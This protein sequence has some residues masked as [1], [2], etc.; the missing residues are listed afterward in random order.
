V[1][2]GSGPV[3]VIV[4]ATRFIDA[5]P[6]EIPGSEPPAVVQVVLASATRVRIRITDLGGAPLKTRPQ[7]GFHIVA[8]RAA[9]G[10][11]WK[12]PERQISAWDES[13]FDREF[14]G[15][16]EIKAPLPVFVSLLSEGVV[17]ATTQLTT[18]VEE[19]TLAVDPSRLPRDDR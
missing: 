1:G 13:E 18:P 6:I 17:V 9:P 4:T 8:T 16:L 11:R 15:R 12:D 5:D 19:L 3:R 10:E 7:L 14:A 2:V